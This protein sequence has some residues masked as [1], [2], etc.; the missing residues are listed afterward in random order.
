[1]TETNNNNNIADGDAYSCCAS[2]ESQSSL[3]SRNKPDSLAAEEYQFRLDTF[4]EGPIEDDPLSARPVGHTRI[5]PSSLFRHTFKLWLD[6]FFPYLNH[7]TVP[8]GGPTHNW[9]LGIRNEHVRLDLIG[10][11][12][13]FGDYWSYTF[14]FTSM[15]RQYAIRLGPP[16]QTRFATLLQHQIIQ[17]SIA[18]NNSH[19]SPYSTSNLPMPTPTYPVRGSIS[20]HWHMAGSI[21]DLRLP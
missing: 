2:C 17:F 14:L 15:L 11:G 16:C 7:T 13:Q 6:H 21:G 10:I 12:T 8:L 9:L 18:L 20:G 3:V 1:M 5:R 19:Q 4:I